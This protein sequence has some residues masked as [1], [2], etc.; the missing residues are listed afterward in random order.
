LGPDLTTLNRRFQLREIVEA[1]IYPSQ[2]VSDQY[3]SHTL[4]TTD[5]KQH[6]GLLIAGGDNS[7]RIVPSDGKELEIPEEEIEEILPVNKSSMPDGLLNSL[8][9][10]DIADL[11]AFL[12]QSE[13]KENAQM[14]RQRR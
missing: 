13:E 2:V 1:I 12:L 7:K 10:E 8:M 14:A 3:R 6:T 11:F 5:G 4:Y 9:L